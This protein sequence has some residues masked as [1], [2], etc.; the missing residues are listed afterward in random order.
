MTSI[1]TAVRRDSSRGFAAPVTSS[2]CSAVTGKRAGRDE[3]IKPSPGASRLSATNTA[4]AQLAEHPPF[5]WDVAGSTPAGGTNNG[6]PAGPSRAADITTLSR[7]RL[8]CGDGA[9]AAQ[10][11]HKPTSPGSTPGPAT[12]TFRAGEIGSASAGMKKAG[13]A[14]PAQVTKSEV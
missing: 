6:S 7:V 11:S 2:T 5:K 14:T 10:R 9:R 1:S 8:Y 3:Q 13:A 12:T 4:V